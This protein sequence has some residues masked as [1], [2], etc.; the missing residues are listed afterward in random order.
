[1][2]Y[3]IKERAERLASDRPQPSARTGRFGRSATREE[4]QAV[5]PG[6]DFI[7]N[8]KATTTRAITIRRT[9]DAVW[10]WIAQLGQKRGGFYSYA[11]LENLVGCDIHNADRIVP[12]WQQPQVG[13]D[14]Q[15]APE[16]PLTV[17]EVEPGRTLVV[18]GGRPARNASAS[19]SFTWA[20]ALRDGP[21]GTTRLV[22]RE[23]Y[24]YGHWW[25]HLL[26]APTRAISSVMS[27][28]MLLGIRGRAESSPSTTAPTRPHL[29][30]QAKS[31]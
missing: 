19:L 28:K 9:P 12:E 20:F 17:A 30:Q 16:V 21:N 7:P 2:L 5:L 24:G 11:W 25:L 31:R 26:V 8:A 18:Q 6:D 29:K 1:M 13:D 14:V 10:P 27:R 22:V 23:R 4:M 3:G 15:L